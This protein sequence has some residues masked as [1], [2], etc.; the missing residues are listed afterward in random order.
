MIAFN[1]TPNPSAAPTGGTR[2]FNATHSKPAKN[3]AKENKQ[4]T[5]LVPQSSK[6][7][8]ITEVKL[9]PVST[10]AKVETNPPKVP[11][12]EPSASS[13]ISSSAAAV[14]PPKSSPI[15][16]T[17]S[18]NPPVSSTNP[19]V[20]SNNPKIG[21]TNPSTNSSPIFEEDQE[22]EEM[23][24]N[25]NRMSMIMQKQREVTKKSEV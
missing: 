25:T 19:P 24:K 13:I 23:R 16:S 14:N 7:S 11:L 6:S 2:G 1:K 4:P 8:S 18:T 12:N 5:P 17:S 9:K 15:P 3:E 22:L 10:T 20:S 21:S